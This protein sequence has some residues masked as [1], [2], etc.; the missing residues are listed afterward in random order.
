MLTLKLFL[1]FLLAS[2]VEASIQASDVEVSS[3]TSLK[4]NSA[5]DGSANDGSVEARD[6]AH[7]QPE[8]CSQL[9]N[10][11]AANKTGH[12]T[13]SQKDDHTRSQTD[14]QTHSQTNNTQRLIRYLEH[15]SSEQIISPLRLKNFYHQL[16]SGSTYEPLIKKSQ[17]H[18]HPLNLFHQRMLQ[19]YLDAGLDNTQLKTWLQSKFAQSSEKGQPSTPK[20]SPTPNKPSPPRHSKPLEP[21]SEPSTE[22]T[23]PQ[24]GAAAQYDEPAQDDKAAQDNE[25]VQKADDLEEDKPCSLCELSEHSNNKRKIENNPLSKPDPTSTSS[26][27]DNK[28]LILGSTDVNASYFIT[29]PY[30]YLKNRRKGAVYQAASLFEAHDVDAWQP[31]SNSLTLNTHNMPVGHTATVPLPVGYRPLQ[32]QQGGR[33]QRRSTGEYVLQLSKA[34]D[35]IEL[36]LV[37]EYVNYLDSTPAPRPK[38]RQLDQALEKERQRIKK[39]ALTRVR[40]DFSKIPAPMKTKLDRWRQQQNYVSYAAQHLSSLSIAELLATYI[41]S[42]FKYATHEAAA[43]L[44]PEVALQKGA[45]QCD[46]AAYIMVAVLRQKFGIPA[47]MSVG[48][49]AFQNT[50]DP[51]RSYIGVPPPHIAHA[52]VDVWNAATRT[53]SAFD[54]TP[55]HP[56]HSSAPQKWLPKSQDAL[57][58][59]TN[60]Q[61]ADP[62][63]NSQ[64]TKEN[65]PP[66]SRSEN[67][68]QKAEAPSHSEQDEQK[69]QAQAQAQAE[70]Q[71]EA[72]PKPQPKAQHEPPQETFHLDVGQLNTF[73]PS[74]LV[75][76]A[77]RLIFQFVLNPSHSGQKTEEQLHQMNSL[78][79]DF[80]PPDSYYKLHQMALSLHRGG[81]PPLSQWLELLN[82]TAQQG[83]IV[84][85]YGHTHT[86]SEALNL[87]AQSLDP[88]HKPPS[89][90]LKLLNEAKSELQHLAH[91]RSHDIG[92][93][94]HMFTRLPPV[95]RRILNIDY[96]LEQVGD[97]AATFK[98]FEDMKAS[99]LQHLQLVATL[100]PLTNF[101]LNSRVKPEKMKIKTWQVQKPIGRDFLPLK[102]F[103]DISRAVVMQ[104]HKTLQ[105]NM[106]EQSVF[107]PY[108]RQSADVPRYYGSV[109]DDERLSLVLYDTS[110]SMEGDAAQFQA[111]LIAAFTA[112]ALSD[113]SALGRQRHKVFIVPFGEQTYTPTFVRN[114]GQAIEV[115]RHYES[116]FGNRNVGT[117]IQLAL[118]DAMNLIA[119]AQ[120]GVN[121][122]LAAAHIIL[123]TDGQS[124]IDAHELQAARAKIH[125]NTSLQVMFVAIH[126]SQPDLINFAMQSKS[127]GVGRGF[128]REFDT[129]R[130]KQLLHQSKQLQRSEYDFY[131][132]PDAQMPTSVLKLIER[133]HQAAVDYSG[134]ARHN[135]LAPSSGLQML[136]HIK[137]Q[138]VW[139]MKNPKGIKFSP[140]KKPIDIVGLRSLMT[141]PLFDDKQLTKFVVNDIIHNFYNITKLRLN[142]LRN[143]DQ[144]HLKFFIQQNL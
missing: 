37:K 107:A 50:Q 73:S 111:A 82:H 43:H 76:R 65:E 79:H 128:Y 125:K 130:I 20:P 78:I 15:L 117:N 8:N 129:E 71:A 11:E 135:L 120:G 119:E 113:V 26:P 6:L 28:L 89:Q 53:W 54:P 36:P 108:R 96:G 21:S 94:N 44:T 140:S 97:N 64:A 69:A 84:N 62:S 92:V 58:Q 101:I 127:M 10:S 85:T 34:T 56:S 133:A 9:L 106:Q 95:A 24:D 105:Q 25:A 112:R 75:H 104:P 131:P 1:F 66:P 109:D 47:R 81:H 60:K 30:F 41:R 88:H 134:P 57:D 40:L 123:M 59:K 90:L 86:I 87:Y 38:T 103:S 110:G 142:Q 91:P 118:L 80:V 63:Q 12:K 32:P 23:R 100:T 83:H 70:T 29:K 98:V 115:V 77:L 14:N 114:V 18:A 22:N 4:A 42:N 126:D 102:R 72:K 35:S 132:R 136:E 55:P 138:M 51:T 141:H 3:A 52:W 121:R 122:P 49:Q 61:N 13:D 45:F 93:V 48:W 19:A 27:E 67:D 39:A 31:T 99:N 5:N 2:V 74:P 7:S 144:E 46:T 143:V 17:T 139:D 124:P 137:S 116:R 68:N 16:E 33:V